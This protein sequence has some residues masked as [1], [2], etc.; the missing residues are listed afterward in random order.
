[1]PTLKINTPTENPTIDLAIDT[2]KE[3]KQAIV[4]VNSKASAEK[5]AEDIS[6][7][8]SLNNEELAKLSTQILKA[9]SR[10]TKQCERLANCVKNG[11]AYH[12]AGL[13]AKQRELIE[14]SFR[15][16]KIK[17][18][19]ATPTLAYGLDLPAYRVII[20]D[21]RRF[22]PRGMAWIPVLE[23]LQQAGR[24]GRPRF[25]KRG[26]AIAVAKTELEKDKIYDKY[27]SGFPE[28]IYSKLAV[29]PVLRT[30]VL[31]LIVSGFVNTKQQLLDL[32]EKTFWAYQ[33]QD[34]ERMDYLITKT[35]ELLEEYEF[36]MFNEDTNKL[37]ATNVGVRVSQLYLDPYTAHKL[38]K[39]LQ[40]AASEKPKVFAYIHLVCQSLEIRPFLRVR[41]AEY[42][43]VQEQL[44]AEEVIVLEPSMYD[45]EHDD[46]LDASKTA[47]MLRDWIDEH[48]EGFLLE[49]YKIR[50]GEHRMKLNVADWLIYSTV[51]LARVLFF[52][53]IIADL[54]KT[55]VRL[56]YGVKEELL[57]L[58][59]LKNIGRVR[60]RKLYNN[61]LKTTID[62]KKASVE[63]LTQILGGRK[64]AENLKEQLGQGKQKV[65][66]KENKRKGQINIK[67]F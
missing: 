36:I 60:A 24:A 34:P 49:K 6:K 67:D 25:D 52:K 55:R 33:Y 45:P 5:T 7:K 21:L 66:V 62:L 20:R 51:E 43:Q 28:N 2:L 22:G 17:I 63:T 27:V 32:F 46:Y 35:I 59:K 12:H 10:P 47:L 39:G 37:K 18:I 1:M 29:E 40:R 3:E 53:N 50:P 15:E 16:G 26:E 31:S 8:A 30:Y 44:L 9:L 54:M 61:K 57:P 4:F 42:D 48:D 65:L 58:L 56:K 14:D 38:I 64:I 13:V 23:Y 11:V 41:S 19:C